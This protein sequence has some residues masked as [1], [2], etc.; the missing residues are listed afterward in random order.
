MLDIANLGRLLVFLGLG[1]AAIGALLWGLSRTKLPIGQ[2]PGDLSFEFSN[3][4]CFI[5]LATMVVV[6]LL[7]TLV[8]NVILRILNK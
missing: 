2:L 4:S 5:P 1:L 7:L 8:L 6:S 3:V